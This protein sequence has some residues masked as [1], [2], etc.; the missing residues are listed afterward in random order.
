MPGT[1]VGRRYDGHPVTAPTSTPPELH[2]LERARTL[3]RLFRR[4]QVDPAP[5]YRFLAAEAAR[6]LERRH[7]PL[8]GTVVGDLGCGPGWYTE[9]FRA[10]GAVVLPVEGSLDELLGG[11]TPPPGAVI[12]DAARLPVPDGSLDGVFCS[13]MLEHT[14]DPGAVIR[15]MARVVRPG[16]WAYLSWTNWYSPWGGHDMT[17]YQ[18]LGPRL[19]PKLYE[20]RHGPP[21][22]NRYG[23]G[24]FACHIGPTLR[25]AGSVP[26]LRIESVEPR[27]WPWASFVMRVPGVREVLAWNCVIRFTREAPALVAAPGFEAALAS[28][29]DVE[30]WM[31]RDQARRLWD[32]ASEVKPG[33]RIV[34]IGSYRGRSTIVLATAVDDGVE[35]VAVDPHAGNDRGP[36]QW[37]GTPEEGQGDHEVFLRNLRRA[38]VAD[39]VRHVREF[40]EQALPHV[41]GEIDLLYVDGAHRYVPA[42]ND[43]VRYGDLVRD[44][45]TMLV[46]DSFSSVG[47]TLALLRERAFSSRWRYVGRSGSMTEYRKEPVGLRGRF[48]NA[49]RHAAGLPWFAKNLVIKL[50]VLARLVDRPWPY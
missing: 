8:D 28:V 29:A 23:E 24:L 34:E 50:A 39:R 33:G 36:Q 7:G 22:K 3:W 30:G 40:S 48:R 18:F 19:G 2:G 41:G 16:G 25:L 49:A 13:N 27:Y 5:F 38:G 20:R 31:T 10:R 26:G 47:V 21:R 43:V 46:H 42:R 32:R 4:E 44:G 45:G 35:V 14:P 12:G 17:P 15:E 37:E 1:P 9:A 11:G 6:D